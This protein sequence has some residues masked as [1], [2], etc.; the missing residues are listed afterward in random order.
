MCEFVRTKKFFIKSS[1]AGLGSTATIGV[2]IADKSR[3]KTTKKKRVNEGRKN[4][5]THEHTQTAPEYN[6]IKDNLVN[7]IIPTPT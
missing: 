5:E 6:M 2:K 7:K 1:T 3:K 4:K